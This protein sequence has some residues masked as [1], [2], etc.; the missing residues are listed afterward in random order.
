MNVGSGACKLTDG[1]RSTPQRR[2]ISRHTK[3][4]S[5]D[6]PGETSDPVSLTP[7]KVD[8]ESET[9]SIV[10]PLES[11]GP[12]RVLCNLSS[13]SS[14]ESRFNESGSTTPVSGGPSIDSW[15]SPLIYINY[16]QIQYSSKELEAILTAA[17]PPFYTE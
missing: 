17:A 5:G 6:S 10:C 7:E 8:L 16:L 2:I 15:G 3:R 11:C 12:V 14:C 4:Y 1:T 9:V 13:L